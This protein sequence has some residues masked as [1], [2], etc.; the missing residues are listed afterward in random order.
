MDDSETPSR[1]FKL[2]LIGDSGVGKTSI[3]YRYCKNAYQEE[4]APTVGLANHPMIVRKNDQ[5][6]KLSIWDTAGQEK[7][8]T[9]T[10]TYYRNCQAAI[11]VY[12]IS[13][14]Q[15][16]DHLESLWIPELNGIISGFL[17]MI[18][19][20]KLDLRSGEDCEGFVSMKTGEQFAQSHGALFVESSAKTAEQVKELFDELTTRL[21]EGAAPV[22]E[23]PRMELS[24]NKA[25]K[26]Q[27]WSCC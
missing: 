16:L 18:V 1:S 27:G 17:M 23:P 24:E 19:G 12:D 11:L 10:N 21:L 8:K 9:L 26:D 6:I 14:P 13:R 2:I 22:A 25:R 3:I 7:F 15:T 20:N 5:C 4:R